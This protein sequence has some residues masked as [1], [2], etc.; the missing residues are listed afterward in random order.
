MFAEHGYRAV[1]LRSITRAC[2]ANIAAVHYHFGSK[3][4]LLERIFEA[5]CSTMN[6]ERLRL[7]GACAP[8]PGRPPRL[9]QILNA[10]LRP[11]L[12][13]PGGDERA[14]RFMRPRAALAQEKGDRPPKLLEEHFTSVAGDVGKALTPKYT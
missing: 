3:E 13:L 2:D 10:Y 6:D 12:V 5:R 8:G 11:A 14:R 4:A 7:L 9:E 1:S